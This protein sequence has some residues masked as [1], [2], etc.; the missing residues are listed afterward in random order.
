MALVFGNPEMETDCKRI[1]TLMEPE[2]ELVGENAS[3][4]D[5]VTTE[6]DCRVCSYSSGTNENVLYSFMLRYWLERCA[7]CINKLNVDL[8]L[9]L[10]K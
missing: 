3:G 5:D 8:S 2:G 1:D 4:V 7:T 6:N 10:S 9:F